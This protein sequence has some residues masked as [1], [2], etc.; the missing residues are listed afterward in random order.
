[1]YMTLLLKVREDRHGPNLFGGPSKVQ[2][3][4]RVILWESLGAGENRVILW[5]S[6]GAGEEEECLK[7]LQTEANWAI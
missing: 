7:V 4:V 1:M 5:E 2:A 3:K 6:L